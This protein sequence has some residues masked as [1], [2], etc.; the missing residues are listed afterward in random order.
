MKHESQDGSGERDAGPRGD[1]LALW[2][3]EGV[4]SVRVNRILVPLDPTERAAAV[5]GPVG[6]LARLLGADLVLFRAVWVDPSDNQIA[7]TRETESTRRTAERALEDEVR[8]LRSRGVRATRRVVLDDDPAEAI[9][10]AV[11]ETDAD[12]V[13]LTTPGRTGIR[14]WLFSSVAERVARKSARPVLVVP[15]QKRK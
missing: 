3:L 9:L 15:T 2:D 4:G 8:A 1:P 7:Y 11:D 10:R 12:L 5:L 14:R 13:V 6:N